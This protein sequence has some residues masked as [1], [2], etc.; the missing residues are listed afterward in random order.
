MSDCPNVEMR[1]QLPEYL[2]EALPAAEHA[3]VASHLATCEACQEELALLREVRAAMGARPVPAI[4]TRAIVAALPRPAARRP[5]ATANRTLWRMAATVTLIAIG[6]TSLTV[7]RR[8]GGER[9]AGGD[10]LVAVAPAPVAAVADTPVLRPDTPSAAARPRGLT[11]GGGVAD[12]ADDDLETLI[13]ALDRL[14]AAPHADPDA[15]ALTR[16]VPGTTGGT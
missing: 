16:V 6:G 4:D 5:V 12:L 10:T 7:L 8:S 2:H 3:R 13:G 14:E 9:P 11:A 15:G 1:E